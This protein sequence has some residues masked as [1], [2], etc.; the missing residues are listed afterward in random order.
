MSPVLI[1]KVQDL[2]ATYL[3]AFEDQLKFYLLVYDSYPWT[4]WPHLEK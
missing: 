1:D 2:K 3:F 4:Q